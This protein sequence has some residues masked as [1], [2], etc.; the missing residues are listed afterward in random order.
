[1]SFKQTP[2][3]LVSLLSVTISAKAVTP[4]EIAAL[5][6]RSP[7]PS[8]GDFDT[9]GTIG[10]R[11][12]A[13]ST[14][15]DIIV[16]DA[17][18]TTWT[19]LGV[20]PESTQSNPISAIVSNS[21]G[22]LMTNFGGYYF[23]TD[24]KNF[25][26]GRFSIGS[27]SIGM[28]SAAGTDRFVAVGRDGDIAWSADG[29]TWTEAVTVPVA[30]NLEGVAFGNG[31]FV[32]GG[33]EGKL[34][35][36]IDGSSWTTTFDGIP[37][38]TDRENDFIS[39][40]F[41][42]GLFF[43]G[44]YPDTLY[45]SPDGTAWTLR[46]LAA[47][48]FN[49]GPKSVVHDGTRYVISSTFGGSVVTSNFTNFEDTSFQNSGRVGVLAELGGVVATSGKFGGFVGSLPPGGTV[50]RDGRQRIG[51]DF[52]SVVFSGGRFLVSE[53]STGRI[54]TSATGSVWTLAYDSEERIDSKFAVGNGQTAILLN[55]GSI[56]STTDGGNTFTVSDPGTNTATQDLVFENGTFL[57]FGRGEAIYAG[58]DATMPF[59]KSPI[60]ADF[61]TRNLTYGE[62]L[63][64][65]V[66]LE[67]KVITSPDAVTWTQRI[68]GVEGGRAFTA[69][70]YVGGRFVAFRSSG[71]AVVSDN[72]ITWDADPS[73]RSF[74]TRVSGVDPDL[75]LYRFAGQPNIGYFTDPL[76]LETQ[77]VASL[78][79]AYSPAGFA[80]G[81]GSVVLVGNNGLILSSGSDT[82]GYDGWVLNN[83][84]IGATQTG[85]ADDFD[86]DGQ[87]NLTEYAR[88]TDPTEF[89][90]N[91]LKAPTK[92]V[93]GPEITFTQRI[94]APG[95]STNVE[96]STDLI[97]WFA[98]GVSFD[99]VPTGNAGFERVTAR[100]TGAPGTAPELY[101]RVRWF[102]E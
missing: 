38:K 24:L 79:T 80:K 41:A 49:G 25:T 72:G 89:T 55:D 48:D 62:G 7:V 95:V 69:I 58:S 2:A 84:P 57:L 6:P 60:P 23:T 68:S 54:F 90:L 21:I 26:S 35:R 76:D 53:S 8:A 22:T 45:S 27:R 85:P 34:L 3:L 61:Y 4:E 5:V 97:D 29:T 39:V 83:F 63:Y 50:W 47:A 102:F 71:T 10:N 56:L 64:V 81:N 36:S 75:G 86:K 37:G 43:A 14:T 100:V 18:G 11:F 101:M 30:T 52:N 96:Y 70:E 73:G 28:A 91:F 51:N 31:V 65:A 74:F 77:K 82:T 42:N 59:A 88:G 32:A 1:M 67:A 44:A 78:S 40:S 98:N 66:S 15:S 20:L 94:A 92:T 99:T 93:F 87:Q 16:G 12:V 19:K 33:D 13:V 46:D 17:A 9:I